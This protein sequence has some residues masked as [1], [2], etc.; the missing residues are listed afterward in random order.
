MKK[1]KGRRLF[2]RYWVTINMTNAHCGAW[3]D[4]SRVHLEVLGQY[5]WPSKFSESD[6]TT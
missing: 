2:R 4:D 1:T 3:H 6:L 5:G